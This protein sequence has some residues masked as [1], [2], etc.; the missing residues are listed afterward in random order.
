[1]SIV[2]QVNLAHALN[3]SIRTALCDWRECYRDTLPQETCFT[4]AP[5]GGLVGIFSCESWTLEHFTSGITHMFLA[6][7]HCLCHVLV[8]GQAPA[9]QRSQSDFPDAPHGQ[10]GAT[11]WQPP[12][13]RG[14][15][16]VKQNLSSSRD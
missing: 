16:L 7:S 4:I 3:H 14:I 11:S 13:M 1:M 12:T 8:H 2:R 15:F 5:G 9:L 6:S 10:K